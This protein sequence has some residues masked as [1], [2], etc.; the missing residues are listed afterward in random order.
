MLG[1]SLR[2]NVIYVCIPINIHL[3]TGS[4][5]KYRKLCQKIETSVLNRGRFRSIQSSPN[6]DVNNT[7]IN[8]NN[9]NNNNNNTGRLGTRLPDEEESGTELVA[10]RVLHQINENIHNM[11][12][13]GEGKQNIWARCL[14]KCFILLMGNSSYCCA[15]S[16]FGTE[17]IKWNLVKFEISEEK[18]RVALL[19]RR[20]WWILEWISWIHVLTPNSVL[21]LI[22]SP[23]EHFGIKKPSYIKKIDM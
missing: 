18:L 20:W 17:C 13:R 22:L 5:R 10:P 14:I 15:A 6:L 4:S 16:S 23:V 19:L 21:L 1:L 12:I 7:P 3:L 9:N 11:K 8:N 2:I